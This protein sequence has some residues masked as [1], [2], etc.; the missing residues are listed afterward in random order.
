NVH[1][2]QNSGCASCGAHGIAVYGTSASGSIHDVVIDGNEVHDCTLGWSE[3]L[4]VNGNVEDFTISNNVV[5]DNNNIGIVAIGFEGEC[6][7]CSDALDR[8]RDGL[9]AGNL[10]YNIDSLGNPSYGN[11]RSADGI[12]IDGGTNIVIERNVVHHSSIGI[13][14][15]SEHG[16][17]TTS[18]VT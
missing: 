18:E 5:H 3:S 11:D 10:V 6:I 1:H 13:E 17:K 14:I 2:I 15:A 8:A 9:I 7:G 4:V 12:Y 16:G